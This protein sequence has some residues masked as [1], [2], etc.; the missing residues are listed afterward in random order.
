MYWPTK[1]LCAFCAM[2]EKLAQLVW[3]YEMEGSLFQLNSSENHYSHG[4]SFSSVLEA[5]Y[6]KRTAF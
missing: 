5:Y 6:G 3:Q 4:Y 1:I 2:S